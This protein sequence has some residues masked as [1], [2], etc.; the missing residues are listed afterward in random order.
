MLP[1]DQST[2]SKSHFSRDILT[3]VTG[4]TIA[5]IITILAS[6]V[7]TRLYGPEAFG[8]L[9]I[10]TSITSIISVIICLRY[11]PA[12]MLPKSDEEAANVFGLCILIV[13][14]IEYPVNP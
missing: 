13:L 9:A 4:T 3:L 5:Q 12:I 1:T 6:P 10:F 2:S 11:E 8:L 14:R 7:I